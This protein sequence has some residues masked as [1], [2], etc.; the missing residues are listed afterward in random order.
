MVWQSPAPK[1]AIKLAL[2]R[3][4][5]FRVPGHCKEKTIQHGDRLGVGKDS[6]LAEPTTTRTVSDIPTGDNQS[7]WNDGKTQY[8]NIHKS[9]SVAN[10]FHVNSFFVQSFLQTR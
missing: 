9:H 1:N 7:G 4:H 3:F 6:L 5:D 10:D 8:T 2:G